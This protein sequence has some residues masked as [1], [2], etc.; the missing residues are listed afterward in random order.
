MH[1]HAHHTALTPHFPRLLISPLLLHALT[2][3]VSFMASAGPGPPHVT[4]VIGLLAG[5]KAEGRE[6]ADP[7]SAELGPG[8]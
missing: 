8:S 7:S 4:F 1:T 2:L 5:I 6:K 3:L